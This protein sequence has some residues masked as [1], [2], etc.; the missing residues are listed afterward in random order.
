M[1]PASS[2]ASSAV[3]KHPQTC[4]PYD[5]ADSHS[6]KLPGVF[7]H[8]NA[9]GPLAPIWESLY[10]QGTADCPVCGA[11]SEYRRPSQSADSPFSAILSHDLFARQSTISID[12]PAQS[13]SVRFD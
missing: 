11:A 6:I 9:L 4:T 8:H 12:R 1:I 7:R 2:S 13:S 10:K 3:K 5:Q